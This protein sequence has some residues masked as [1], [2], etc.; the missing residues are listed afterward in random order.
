[1]TRTL[2][3]DET[4][5]VG[6]EK[7]SNSSFTN[8]GVCVYPVF[9][10]EE[11]NFFSELR[12]EKTGVCKKGREVI[13]KGVANL[14]ER[15]RYLLPAC[16]TYTECLKIFRFLGILCIITY[17]YVHLENPGWLIDMF[18]ASSGRKN[19]YHSDERGPQK[20]YAG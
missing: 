13:M 20:L 19:E 12:A 14:K 2:K 4:S 1:M 10:K 8:L 15:D 6:L 9:R 11:C 18:Y 17:F 16:Y 7:P 3:V 5:S